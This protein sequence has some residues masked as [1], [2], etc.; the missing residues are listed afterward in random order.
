MIGDTNEVIS[1]LYDKSTYDE[2]LGKMKEDP[3][4]NKCIDNLVIKQIKDTQTVFINIA[5]KE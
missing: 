2:F 5:L 1:N 3:L 4:L